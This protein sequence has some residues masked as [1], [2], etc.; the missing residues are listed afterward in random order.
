MFI[1]TVIVIDDDSGDNG[2]DDDKDGDGGHNDSGRDDDVE[3]AKVKIK[4]NFVDDEAKF[5]DQHKG[6]DN[7]SDDDG[8]P[9]RV[10][11]LMMG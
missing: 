4:T 9:K 10:L 11:R 3:E 6:N 1:V 7:Y 5:D 2:Y 8:K